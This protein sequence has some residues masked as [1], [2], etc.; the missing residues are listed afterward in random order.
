MN[1]FRERSAMLALFTGIILSLAVLYAGAGGGGKQGRPSQFVQTFD[2]NGNGVIDADEISL[3]TNSLNRLDVNHDGAISAQE[4]LSTG[5][6][7]GGGNARGPHGPQGN[8][9]RYNAP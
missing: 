8:P 3:A 7:G 2:M 6:Q 9:A 5:G 1:H 4:L